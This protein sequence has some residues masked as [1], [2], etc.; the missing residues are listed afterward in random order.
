M[1]KTIAMA[2]QGGQCM[3]RVTAFVGSARKKHT[4]EAARRFLNNLQSLGDV[5]TEIVALSDY[6]LGTCR[7]CKVCFLK[8]EEFCP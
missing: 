4:Y 8:G 6:R 2:G 7:G 5:E 3:K 1:Q